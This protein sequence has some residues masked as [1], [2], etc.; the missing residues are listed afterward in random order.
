M[1]FHF[2]FHHLALILNITLYMEGSV[3]VWLLYHHP[4][5]QNHTLYGGGTEL[6][7]DRKTDRQMDNLITRY[8]LQTF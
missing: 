4:S 8:L 2:K 5:F 7:T 1:N 6:R 3:Q